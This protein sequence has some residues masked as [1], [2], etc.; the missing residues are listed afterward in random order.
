[1]IKLLARSKKYSTET[2]TE[3][4]PNEDKNMKLNKDGTPNAN[5][6]FNARKLLA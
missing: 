3:Y 6:R 4:D 2:E 1:M 5:S